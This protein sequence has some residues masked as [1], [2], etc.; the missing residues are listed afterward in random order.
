VGESRAGLVQLGH[1]LGLPRVRDASPTFSLGS[2]RRSWQVLA[3]RWPTVSVP[4][5]G[6]VLEKKHKSEGL[7]ANVRDTYE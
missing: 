7:S 5:P 2:R 1:G 3:T 4:L 6:F